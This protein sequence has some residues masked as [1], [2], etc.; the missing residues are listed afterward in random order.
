MRYVEKVRFHNRFNNSQ[1]LSFFP[2]RYHTT[3]RK[4]RPG[5]RLSSSS[6]RT[7]ATDLRNAQVEALLFGHHG[8]NMSEGIALFLM[9]WSS[10]VTAAKHLKQCHSNKGICVEEKLVSVFTVCW[11][12]S[13]GDGSYKTCMS[14]AQNNMMARFR[15]NLG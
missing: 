3:P 5:N 13:H 11:I 2:C 10:L 7:T 15:C 9:L 8:L 1:H 4:Q 6:L 12:G 14:V